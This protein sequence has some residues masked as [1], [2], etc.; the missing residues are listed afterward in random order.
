MN[1]FFFYLN[2]NSYK[3]GFIAK[4]GRQRTLTGHFCQPSANICTTATSTSTVGKSVSRPV[5]KR[6]RAT[7]E[8][9]YDL[10]C[11]VLKGQLEEQKLVKEKTI[12]QIEL[13]KQLSQDQG[14]G[15]LTGSQL[16]LFAALNWFFCYDLLNIPYGDWT[17]IC[18]LCFVYLIIFPLSWKNKYICSFYSMM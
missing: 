15:G 18:V 2:R 14:N 9:A 17:L 16:A 10:Q 1:I 13:L 11:Q 4:G 3:W 12:L 8:D 6:K 5:T 7:Q